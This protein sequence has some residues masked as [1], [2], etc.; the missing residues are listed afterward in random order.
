MGRGADGLDNA[1]PNISA[2]LLH[3]FPQILSTPRHPPPLQFIPRFPLI[4]Q[5]NSSPTRLRGFPALSPAPLLAFRSLSS[6]LSPAASPALNLHVPEPRVLPSSP[7]AR[8]PEVRAT[9]PRGPGQVPGVCRNR[10][11]EAESWGV[12]WGGGPNREGDPGSPSGAIQ[13]PSRSSRPPM[14]CSIYELARDTGSRRPQ[15]SQ[16]RKSRLLQVTGSP[17]SPS[18]ESHRSGRSLAPHAHPHAPLRVGRR[19]RGPR[20][21][22]DSATSEPDSRLAPGQVRL[23]CPQTSHRPGCRASPPG[24]RNPPLVPREAA[25]PGFPS[26]PGEPS[27]SSSQL[28]S[29]D[30]PSDPRRASWKTQTPVALVTMAFVSPAPWAQLLNLA[31]ACFLTCKKEEMAGAYPGVL[32]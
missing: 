12:G 6:I 28:Q 14:R 10:P 19:K 5:D 27:A 26:I 20:K 18:P 3:L 23:P 15:V 29:R 25:T 22:W 21:A 9:C 7:A 11:P 16:P 17:D 4:P 8:G 24:D 1:V 31:A 2:F 30:T 32:P 13:P